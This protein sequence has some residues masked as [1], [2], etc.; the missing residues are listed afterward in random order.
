[1]SSLV[2]GLEN[3]TK[4]EHHSLARPDVDKVVQANP[5]PEPH[6]NLFSRLTFIWALPLLNKG[7]KKT[8][9]MDDIWSLHPKMLSY[10]LFLSTQARID[11]DEAIARQKTQNLAENKTRATSGETTD[12]FQPQKIRLFSIL[13]HTVGWAYLTA[14]IPCLLYTFAMYSS[15]VLLTGLIAFMTSYT[16]GSNVTEQ[17]VWKGYGLMLGVLTT[18]VLCTV[19]NAQYQNICFQSSI[20]ARGVFNSLIYRKALR[21]SST[22]KQEGMG[23]IVNHMSI[24]VDNVLQLFEIFHMLWSSIIGV[25]I[26]LVLL[27]RQVQYA[28]FAGLGVTAGIAIVGGFISSITGK[29]Y[30]QMSA[31]N[32]H[33]IET[34]QRASQPYQANQAVCLGAVLYTSDL[35]GALE[36]TQLPPLVVHHP[37]QPNRHLQR[38]HSTHVVRL[39][40]RIQLHRPTKCHLEP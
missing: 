39:A 27:Y 33:R 21:L 23:S 5:L 38:G 35:R 36:T 10:P 22:N 34:R 20:C 6:A 28:M 11:A 31:K 13:V 2:F 7:K 40:Y 14:A 3:I 1:M 17:P 25:V 24:D 15:P 4:P 32:D 8:L 30:E 18:S 12:T 37:H 16:E 29:V 19:F 9:K 26:A